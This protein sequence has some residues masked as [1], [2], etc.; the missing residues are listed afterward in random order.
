MGNNN[1]GPEPVGEILARLF[2]SRGWG[3]KSERQRLEQAWSDAVGPDLAR[4]T[5]V[6]TLRRA[7]LEI[8]VRNAILV[9][10][11]S[12]FHKK[13]LLE[14]LRRNLPGIRLADLKF[15]VANW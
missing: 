2:A 15:R 8:E 1:P 7:V 3:R 11:M 13:Q 10:E 9:Q 12:L 4:L 5:R 6:G 14:R